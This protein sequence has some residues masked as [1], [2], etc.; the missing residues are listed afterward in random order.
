MKKNKFTDFLGKEWEFYDMGTAIVNGE[1]EVPGGIIYNGKY[2]VLNQDPAIPIPG[3]L[4]IT[5]KR[6][7]NSFSLLTKEEREE[8]SE[9]LFKTEKILKRINIA[10]SFTLVQEDRCPHFHI[11][12]FPDGNWANKEYPIGAKKIYDQLNYSKEN[13]NQEIINQ[14]L[15]TVR[16]IK[17]EWN[18]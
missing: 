15:E 7:I 3:F 18:K 16:I 9:V 6:H 1:L 17:E 14:T 13:A 11:W 5:L 12:I 8:I 10:E 2:L 4:I